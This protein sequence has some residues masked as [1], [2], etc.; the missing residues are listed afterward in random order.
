MIISLPKSMGG[1][2]H[3][4]RTDRIVGLIDLYPTLVDLC[5]L[6]ANEKAEGR[7]LKPC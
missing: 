6:P 7:S 1:E 5:G 3:T 4:G 2:K